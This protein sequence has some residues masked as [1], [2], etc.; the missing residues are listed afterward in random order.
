MARAPFIS[1][2]T[3]CALDAFCRCGDLEFPQA[4]ECGGQFVTEPAHLAGGLEHGQVVEPLAPLTVTAG[5]V[6]TVLRSEAAVIA[7]CAVHAA[8]SAA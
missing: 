2:D 4:C 6:V 8:Q 1:L 5:G 3:F 7:F